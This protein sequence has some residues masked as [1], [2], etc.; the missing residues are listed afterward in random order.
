MSNINTNNTND[1]TFLIILGVLC[2]C[3]VLF[4]LSASVALVVIA[5][6][7]DVQKAVDEI[8]DEQNNDQ[9][10]SPGPAPGPAP[11]S[12]AQFESCFNEGQNKSRYVYFKAKSLWPEFG[13]DSDQIG[14]VKGDD[15]YLR[16]YK[17][18]EEPNKGKITTQATPDINQAS[19]F[20]VNKEPT[21][22]Y[23]I[24]MYLTDD[25]L[26][27]EGAETWYVKSVG[28]RSV[29]GVG[30]KYY[31]E[32]DE[33]RP[34]DAI[35]LEQFIKITSMWYPIPG[36]RAEYPDNM[37]AWKKVPIP[38]NL[39][40]GHGYNFRILCDDDQTE[41]TFLAPYTPQEQIYFDNW[42]VY[43]GYHHD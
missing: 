24:E 16:Y 14:Y 2:M 35:P 8:I 19:K 6:N 42:A 7:E 1:K 20:Y 11:G 25:G 18:D 34:N 36:S 43:S 26:Y 5:N 17:R 37:S 21:G 39:F 41:T 32:M 30:Y 12:A 33:T 4:T 22:G 28:E 3:C 31:F 40:N 15:V 27:S 38:K 23:R 10:Q 13:P 29:G 9:S